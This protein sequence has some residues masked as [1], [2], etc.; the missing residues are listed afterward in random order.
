MEIA[1]QVNVAVPAAADTW[2]DVGTFTVPAGVKRLKKLRFG[3]A[4]DWAV[5]AVSVRAAPVFRL[6]GS[7]TL[8]QGDHQYLGISSY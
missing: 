6:I 8:E 1:E 5:T 4:P 2:T 3:L 7:G